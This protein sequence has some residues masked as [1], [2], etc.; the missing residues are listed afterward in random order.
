MLYLATRTHRA[1][2]AFAVIRLR[3]AAYCLPASNCP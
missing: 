3:R 1:R 2:A